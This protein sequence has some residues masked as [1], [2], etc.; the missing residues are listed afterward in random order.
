MG[1]ECGRN[2]EIEIERG[3]SVSRS[4]IFKNRLVS[5]QLLVV[6]KIPGFNTPLGIH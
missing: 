5:D 3:K 2:S 1:F 4:Y 6:L